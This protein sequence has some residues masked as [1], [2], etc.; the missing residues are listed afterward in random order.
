MYNATQ[1]ISANNPF[2]YLDRKEL[3]YTTV[4]TDETQKKW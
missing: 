4:I 3:Y 1:M 2:Q